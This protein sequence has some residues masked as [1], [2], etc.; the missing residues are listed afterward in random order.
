[1]VQEDQD[2]ENDQVFQRIKSMLE[3]LILQAEVALLQKTNKS[4]KV[5]QDYSYASMEKQFHVQGG[6]L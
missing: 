1:M 3:G 5:L 4:G 2:I 6:L